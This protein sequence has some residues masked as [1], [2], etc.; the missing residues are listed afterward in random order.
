MTPPRRAAEAAVLG[1]SLWLA[2]SA[3]AADRAKVLNVYA[4]AEYFPPALVAKFLSLPIMFLWSYS[5]TRRFVFS[6]GS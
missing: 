4:W 3:A 2:M 1:L 6:R 5:M